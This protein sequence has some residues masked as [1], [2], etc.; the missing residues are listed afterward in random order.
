MLLLNKLKTTGFV[1]VIETI[2][3]LL[4]YAWLQV[5]KL[6]SFKNPSPSASLMHI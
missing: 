3:A 6:K 5:S 2:Q 1:A 4:A